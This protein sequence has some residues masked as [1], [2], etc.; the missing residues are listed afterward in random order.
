MEMANSMLDACTPPPLVAAAVLIP[1]TS[2]AALTSGPAGVAGAHGGV[3]LDEVG[4]GA[5]R[6]FD[7]AVEGGHDALGDGH[8]ALE[9]QGVADGDHLVADLD[10]VGV[11]EVG[12]DQAARVV[13]DHHRDVGR[14]SRATTVA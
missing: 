5:G 3:G 12:G 11:A 13:H 1:T 6:R 9:R 7:G 2:P 8:A 10:A 4:E 14:A